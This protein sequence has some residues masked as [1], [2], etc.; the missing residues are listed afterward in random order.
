MDDLCVEMKLSVSSFYFVFSAVLTM[1]VCGLFNNA[2]SSSVCSVDWWYY[3]RKIMLLNHLLGRSERNRE[4]PVSLVG[5]LVE[6]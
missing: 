2:V 5:L 4:K 3:Y 6:V 1:N